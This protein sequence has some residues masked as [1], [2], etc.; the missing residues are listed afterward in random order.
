[1]ATVIGLNLQKSWCICTFMFHEYWYLIYFHLQHLIKN[2]CL[3][4]MYQR[5]RDYSTLKSTWS[6]T[7]SHSIQLIGIHIDHV[8]QISK[9]VLLLPN[10]SN[11]SS[12]GSTTTHPTHL[13]KQTTKSCAQLSFC[14]KVKP[15]V[16]Y[17]TAPAPWSCFHATTSDSQYHRSLLWYHHNSPPYSNSSNFNFRSFCSR[18]ASSGLTCSTHMKRMRTR[19]NKL[20]YFEETSTWMSITFQL[21][22]GQCIFFCMGAGN[23]PKMVSCDSYLHHM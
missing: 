7:E 14:S 5:L 11:G 22:Q 17:G 19:S 8:I 9:V 18:F 21:F 23:F 4:D 1:M 15:I 2:T 6:W 20:K 13:A 16:A 3:Y 10:N 12:T